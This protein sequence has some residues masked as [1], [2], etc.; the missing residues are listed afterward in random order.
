MSKLSWPR[1]PESIGSAVTD[2]AASTRSTLAGIAIA[3]VLLTAGCVGIPDSGPVTAAQVEVDEGSDDLVFLPE[4]PTPGATQEEIVLDFLNAATSPS[5]DYAIAR[6]YLSDDFAAEWD[7]E[8]SVSVRAGQPEV[9]ASGTDSFT[10]DMTLA[11]HVSAEGEYTTDTDE[12]AQL[13]FTLVEQDGEWRIAKAPDGIVLG[14]YPFTTL[15][16]QHEVYFLSADG[17]RYVP[18]TRWFE[19]SSDSLA[20]RLVD[21]LLAGPSAWLAGAVTTSANADVTRVGD[22]DID[23]GVANVTVSYEQLAE[24]SSARLAMLAA[25]LQQ[26]LAGVGVMSVDV[27]IDQAAGFSASD[28][29]APAIDANIVDARPLV[30]IGD[31]LRYVGS[32]TETEVATGSQLA[33]LGAT[34]YQ[35]FADGSAGVAFADGHAWSLANDQDPRDLGSTDVAPALDRGG[36]SWLVPNAAEPE[37]RIARGSERE[38]IELPIENETIRAIEISRDGTRLLVVT[39]VGDQSNV[40]LFGI[41]RDAGVPVAVG[42]AYVQPVLVGTAAD[43]TWIS[44]SQVAVLTTAQ[45]T[46]SVSVMTIGGTSEQLEELSQSIVHIGG[47]STGTSTIRLLTAD[48]AMLSVNTA[49]WRETGLDEPVELIATQIG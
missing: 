20:N 12:A 8:A 49:G 19:R 22:V 28:T 44:D 41:H 25:Q 46:S 42:E 17:T 3:S 18:E 38:T 47:G 40:Q 26:S 30:L 32:G 29:Q 34:S 4:S 1:W 6:D 23:D 35:T 10:V 11:G 9:T 5:D 13:E 37:L 33:N 2:A 27:S 48:G 39:A 24:S 21:S 16:R 14:G 36:W 31:E 45:G 43:A 15:F 7:P